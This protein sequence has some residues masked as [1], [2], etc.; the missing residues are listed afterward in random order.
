MAEMK[1]NGKEEPILVTNDHNLPPSYVPQN[2]QNLRQAR[3]HTET[4]N[5][6]SGFRVDIPSFCNLKVFNVKGQLCWRPWH[7]HL[8]VG[9]IASPHHNNIGLF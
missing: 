1:S 8:P 9:R 7:F 6:R 2:A 4:R 5:S 3:N